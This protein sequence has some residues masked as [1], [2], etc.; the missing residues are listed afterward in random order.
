MAYD[1]THV[2]FV[3]AC[4][5]FWYAALN[6]VVFGTSSPLWKRKR[7][8]WYDY[9]PGIQ[10][11]M[12]IYGLTVYLETPP[13]IRKGRI[14]YII[15]SFLLFGLLGLSSVL[16]LSFLFRLLFNST[17]PEDFIYLRQET[18]DWSVVL[19]QTLNNVVTFLGDGLMVCNSPSIF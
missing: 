4:S 13:S 8:I 19:S 18:N 17:S 2:G 16:D 14:P 3:L 5:M 1:S 15:I 6:L 11:F 7:L 9:D 10:L 12:S